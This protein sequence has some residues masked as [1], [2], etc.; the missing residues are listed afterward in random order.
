MLTLGRNSWERLIRTVPMGLHPTCGHP[1]GRE[2]RVLGEAQEP[3]TPLAANGCQDCQVPA[4]LQSTVRGTLGPSTCGRCRRRRPAMTGS[5]AIQFDN[6]SRREPH[7]AGQR[8]STI[9][10][11]TGRR[12]RSS[13]ES[14]SRIPFGSLAISSGWR[15]DTRFGSAGRG[16]GIGS[17]WLAQQDEGPASG[18]SFS[19][20]GSALQPPC[21]A[22]P[23]TRAGDLKG[24]R[25]HVLGAGRGQ[26][27]SL[28]PRLYSQSLGGDGKKI[29]I[30]TGCIAKLTSRGG[31]HARLGDFECCLSTAP[32][33]VANR[34]RRLS[35]G[36][37]AGAMA[38]G[39]AASSWTRVSLPLQPPD[40]WRG[41]RRCL[42]LGTGAE[43]P[44]Q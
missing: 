7:D 17:G 4:T 10:R 21:A 38:L 43:A 12:D 18:R 20:R 23:A 28:A 27:P 15:S 2:V 41:S 30:T 42:P 3:R 32:G 13:N 39:E 22:S 9:W 29:A 6:R 35:R 16:S 25:S 19:G 5:P 1:Q 24:F 31:S 44:S 37:S 8:R 33:A 34:G 40:D 11:G 36:G 14:V 26:A